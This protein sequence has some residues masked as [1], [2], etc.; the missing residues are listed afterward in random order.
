M[1]FS[2]G[3][4][5]FFLETKEIKRLRGGIDRYATQ[6]STLID[7]KADQ[8]YA[9]TEPLLPEDIAEMD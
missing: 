1:K 2:Y 9:G 4:Q 8:V 3:K 5:A 7:A 6:V